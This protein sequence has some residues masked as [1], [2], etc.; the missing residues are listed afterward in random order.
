MSDEITV[1]ICQAD[2]PNKNNRT[3]STEALQNA[4]DK[5][6]R[7]ELLGTI[8]MPVSDKV[9]LFNVSHSVSNLRLEDGYLVGTMKVL[10]TPQGKMLKE[11]LSTPPSLDF[12][13]AGVGKVDRNGVVSDFTITSV[14]AV[15]DGA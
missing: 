1:R 8:G 3:Y 6:P 2:V 7:P 4:V 11:L 9:D 13:L 10:E 15:Y 12:R 5:L 14:N